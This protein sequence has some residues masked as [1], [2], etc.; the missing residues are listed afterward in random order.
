MGKYFSYLSIS[1]ISGTKKRNSVKTINPSKYVINGKLA[2]IKARGQIAT[3]TLL[4]K[5]IGK[6]R[7]LI[8]TRKGNFVVVKFNSRKFMGGKRRWHQSQ[9]LTGKVGL[10]KIDGAKGLCV[11]G[12]TKAIVPKKKV[13]KPATRCQ[14]RLARKVC[15]A[16]KVP[17]RKLKKCIKIF[18][19]T[20]PPCKK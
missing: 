2:H 5:R 6:N 1:V 19:K 12:E 9:Y 8:R 13:V 3:L 20:N 10:N 15:R 4:V 7:V 14:K 16:R 18:L 17:K 11:S